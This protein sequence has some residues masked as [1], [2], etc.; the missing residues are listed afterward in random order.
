MCVHQGFLLFKG[1]FCDPITDP[2]FKCV[3]PAP[4]SGLDIFI[5]ED[6]LTI[7]R[8]PLPPILDKNRVKLI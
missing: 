7:L 2:S 1:I 3:I 8:A 6:L 4:Q 5:Y